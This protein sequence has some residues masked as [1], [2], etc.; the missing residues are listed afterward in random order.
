MD[1]S[2][3]KELALTKDGHSQ[4]V[5]VNG[6]VSKW[7][8]V[9]SSVRQGFVVGSILFKIKYTLSKFAEDAKLSSAVD[10]LEGKDAIQRDLDRLERWAH[11]TIAA[12]EVLV[13]TQPKEMALS[14]EGRFRLD[15]RK[16]FFTRRVVRH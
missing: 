4:K 1:H 6:S 11:A 12:T 3:D 10:M 14:W 5:V 9:T 8:L 15:N 13:V 16:K 7:R 2:L